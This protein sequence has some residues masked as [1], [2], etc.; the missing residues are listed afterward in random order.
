[1]NG[2]AGL[3]P[4]RNV[5]DT[6]RLSERQEL[7]YHGSKPDAQAK[8]S[9]PS[10]LRLRVSLQ[11]GSFLLPHALQTC[12]TRVE[13]TAPALAFLLSVIKTTFRDLH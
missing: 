11:W 12:P 10:V 8:D 13:H 1:M 2:G 4:A 3:Y 7:S 5:V 9:L 6:D